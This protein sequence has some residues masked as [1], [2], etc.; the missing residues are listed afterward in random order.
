MRKEPIENDEPTPLLERS[1]V[2]GSILVAASLLVGVAGLFHPVLSGDG[3]A[4]LMNIAET[5]GWRVIHWSIS[6]GYVLAVAGLV[7]FSNVLSSTPG[8]SAARLGASLTIFGY[9]VSLVGVL[10]MLGAAPALANTYRASAPGPAANALF[11]YETL[12]PFALAALRVGAFAVSLGVLALGWSVKTARVLPGWLGW[13]GFAAGLVGAGVAA[14]LSEH[15]P[16]IVTGIGLAAVWQL[17][18]GVLLMARGRVT[19]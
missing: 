7:G 13:V 16:A 19:G 4:Q 15:S 1:T 8:A 3:A 2:L 5:R 9:A 6:F 17:V 10:F 14:S 12:H 11:L 18:A